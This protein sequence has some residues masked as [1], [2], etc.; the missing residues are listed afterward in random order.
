MKRMKT[1][2]SII[3]MLIILSATVLFGQSTHKA[4]KFLNCE[5]GSSP[6]A[7]IAALKEESVEIKEDTKLEKLDKEI[8]IREFETDRVKKFEFGGYN[9]D[10]LSLKFLDNKLVKVIL[11]SENVDEWKL[12]EELEAKFGEY[13]TGLVLNLKIWKAEDG[14]SLKLS[15]TRIPGF[16]KMVLITYEVPG[17]LEEYNKKKK[18]ALKKKKTIW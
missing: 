8:G 13:E 3:S 6:E 17:F 14:S 10:C 4:F 7:I 16:E 12:S 5:W 2:K 1:A 9:W 15:V 11:D 18:E